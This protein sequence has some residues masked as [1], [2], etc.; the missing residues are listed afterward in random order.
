[1]SFKK[2]NKNFL[3]VLLFLP[4]LI[5]GLLS[6][7][8]LRPAQADTEVLFNLENAT[9]P[10]LYLIRLQDAPTSR[11]RG[12]ISGYEATSP[13][14]TGQRFNARNQASQRY[15]QYLE[16]RQ[17]AHLNAMQQQL[18][19]QVTPSQRF[20]HGNNGL[21]VWL[22]PEEAARVAQ[23]PNVIYMQ[24]DIERIL[25][26]DAGPSWISTS[27][28]W[29]GIATGGLPGTMGE[30]I[31]V[32]VI[33]TG[34]N[35]LNP[36][37]AEVGPVDGYTHTN[38]KGH[39][40]GVCDPTNTNPPSGTSGYDP[41]FPC[42]DK[43][44]GAWG[45]TSVNGGD[46]TDY[47]G[48]GSHT[49]STSAGNFVT[50][51]VNAPTFSFTRD[52]SGVAP[53]ANIIAYSA[54][55]T[56]SGL[57]AAIDQAIADGVD[58]INYSIGSELASDVWNDFDT[59]GY[60][61]ARAAGI[62]VA[63]SAGNAGPGPET[64]GSPADA[65]WLTSVGASTH[66]RKLH[67]ALI[68]MSGGNT[69]PPANINGKSI[70]SGFGPAEIVYAGDFG[71]ALCGL[72]AFSAGTFNGE[73]VV[74]D[75]GTHARVDKGQSV[76]D[77][78]AGGFILA[79]DADNGNSLSADAHALPAVHISFDDGVI[80]KA[81]IA[82][83]GTSHTGEIEGT[84]LDIN[85]TN[86]DIMAGFSSR[87]ANRAI[88]IISP[89]ITA[90]GVDIVAAYGIGGA[91]EWN[92]ISGT[93]MASP[94]IA[95][96]GALMMS[97]HPDWT[98]AE[99]QSALMTTAWTS[100]LKE[101]GV[102]AADPFDMGS[103]RVDLSVAAEAGLLLDETE[104]NYL[105]ANPSVG[106]D[107]KTINI[108][109]MANSNCV[110][111]CSW[112]RTVESPL[113]VSVDWTASVVNPAG[114]T[115]A[116]SPSSFT[117]P[118]GGSQVL[119]I[120]VNVDA[121]S[122]GEWVF[123]QVILTADGGEAPD[124]HLPVAV[125]TTDVATGVPFTAVADSM[126]S[127]RRTT[128]NFGTSTIMRLDG[129]PDENGY[130]RFDVQTGGAAIT[131]ATLRLYV[132]NDGDASGFDIHAITDNGWGET[133]I[134]YNN[135]PAFG[136]LLGNSGTIA[137]STWV[138]IDVTSHVTSDGLVSFALTTASSQRISISSREG[139]NAPELLVDSGTAPTSTPVPPTP[140]NTPVPPTPTDTPVGPT[141]TDTPVPPTATNTPI[142]PTAT[143]TP[144]PPTATNTPVPPTP[145][146]TPVP[147]NDMHVGDLDGVSIRFGR[148]WEGTVTILIV[149]NGGSPVSN[150]T[151]DGSWSAGDAASSSC[152]TDGSGLCSVTQTGLRAFNSS[153]T[154]TV[155]DVT[156]ATLTYTSGDNTDPDGDSDGTVIT[157]SRP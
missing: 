122:N 154:F 67:N 68:N 125:V 124:A 141:P 34:I 36:S 149:D 84:V 145:T 86:G 56:L 53:H 130:V 101:D 52:I 92:A 69:T 95:G 120:D 113:G 25:H 17:N 26:T 146:Y 93:S 83:G 103:G 60:L 136:T 54:C 118:A 59:V 11:Y 126:V 105:A 106:G 73:I 6:S 147:G 99:I 117:I 22:T 152:T 110:G 157:V 100:V 107:P 45:Y 39:Y 104:A 94:H 139:A 121:D 80:L 14:V 98:P 102:T 78:G 111:A 50:A 33:D 64:V 12:N 96:V 108:A 140:T 129:N 21:T 47:D 44:I 42:N 48:H 57:T 135:A 2:P 151:I 23:L 13:E 24:R 133:S 131:D 35:P 1:M 20:F 144:I 132:N 91:V 79:N 116:V 41:S 72:G 81:W 89:N 123:G 112:T 29:N 85:A 46:P 63:T 7:A 119:T 75:R 70:T 82:D 71:D 155:D 138:E 97:V 62:F 30:D 74:C 5:I 148:E 43:L 27:D 19:R 65:P 90:P 3:F 115:V 9:E 10:G 18:D 15:Q 109:S 58:V 156:H 128:S 87:G 4:V 127:G 37:F 137:N 142:P 40:F 150:A 16:G 49:A 31:V 66:D 143:N 77:G 55:C 28:I 61:N 38:P 8:S 153:V 134:N 76:L 32:G 51:T 88:D 114:A